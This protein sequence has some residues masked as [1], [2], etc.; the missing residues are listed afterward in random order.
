M[1]TDDHLEHH[2]K[3]NTK[4]AAPTFNIDYFVSFLE[5]PKNEVD[6]DAIKKKE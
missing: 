1:T 6:D 2:R 5:P 4:Y 3:L